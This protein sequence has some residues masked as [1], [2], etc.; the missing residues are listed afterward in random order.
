MGEHAIGERRYAT[1]ELLA[2]EQRLLDAA[3]SRTG[4]QAGVCSHETLRETLAA[5]PD[6][7]ADQAAMV[8]DIT[9][10]GQSVSVVVGKAGTGTTYTLGAARHAWQLEGLRVLGAAPTGIATVCLDAEGFEHSRTVDSL[11]G[12]WIGSTPTVRTGVRG[13]SSD[14]G[15]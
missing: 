9:Q 4:E 12:S 13:R 15:T 3:I 2:V 7:R 14:N 11:L 1:P 6:H 8:R 5:H 10:G